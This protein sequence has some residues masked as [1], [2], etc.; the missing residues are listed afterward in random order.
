MQIQN[1]TLCQENEIWF[2]RTHNK[3]WC[4]VFSGACQATG[5]P[6]F[7]VPRGPY[8]APLAEGYFSICCS[9]E[10]PCSQNI[11]PALP[12]WTKFHK[13]NIRCFQRSISCCNILWTSFFARA[14][15]SA[16]KVPDTM[17]CG[18]LVLQGLKS[19]WLITAP[20]QTAIAFLKS[21]ISAY[22]QPLKMP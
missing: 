16:S 1:T 7:R 6:A 8:L 14:T 17:K 20:E 13:V 18:L 10:L 9:R 4:F 2:E 5:P 22:Q 12:F 15:E 11:T 3:F 21:I 19:M